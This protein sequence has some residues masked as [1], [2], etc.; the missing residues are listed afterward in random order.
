VLLLISYIPCIPLRRI[1]ATKLM[2][3]ATTPFTMAGHL[4]I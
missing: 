4:Y 3:Y 1:Q 2:I